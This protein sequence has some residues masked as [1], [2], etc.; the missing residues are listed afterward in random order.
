[1]QIIDALVVTL[2][3]DPSGFRKGQAE[4]DAALKKT[5]ENAT[6]EAKE[7]EARAKGAMTAFRGLRN[8]I[9][10]L[11]GISMSLTGVAKMV[12]RITSSDAA[13]GRLAANLGMATKQ[14]SAWQNIAAN[15]GSSPEGVA[16]LFRRVQEMGQNIMNFGSS[17]GGSEYWLHQILGPEGFAQF[18]SRSATVEERVRMLQKAAAGTSNPVQMLDWFRHIG[19]GDDSFTMFREIGSR[20]DEVLKS[21]Q[22]LNVATERDKQL[23]IERQQAW[24]K[25]LD[26]IDS[27]SRKVLN[28]Y[29]T[30][31]IKGIAGL[32]DKGLG[33]MDLFSGK[34]PGAFWG[35]IW[36]AIK[37]GWGGGPKTTEPAA[38]APA[39]SAAPS[40]GLSYSREGD[41]R[42]LAGLTPAALAASARYELAP[43]RR[44]RNI[45]ELQR[46]LSRSG[47]ND[48]QRA[49]LMEQLQWLNQG[50]AQPAGGRT[51]LTINGGVHINAPSA[52]TG[53]DLAESFMSALR[54]QNLSLATHAASGLK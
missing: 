36:D 5:R 38:A 47:L 48:V 12:E 52:T 15:F 49:A 6:R 26:T 1:M 34:A 35:A 2:G 9:L 23:A 21:Q 42:G 29:L 14:F 53:P 16:S 33:P 31:A 7:I 20:L 11:V 4:T 8:E 18:M 22:A 3:L 19:I 25:L 45:A 40:R 13:T 17:G 50:R 44:E 51:E 32:G 41:L 43:G 46:E 24:K 28:D 39:Q 27:G 54:R 37:K 30:P 10:G